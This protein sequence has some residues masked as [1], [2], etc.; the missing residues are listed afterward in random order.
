MPNLQLL[1]LFPLFSSFARYYVRLRAFCDSIEHKRL[2]MAP[3]DRIWGLGTSDSNRQQL[4]TLRER[5]PPAARQARPVDPKFEDFFGLTCSQEQRVCSL[6]LSI[7]VHD[8]L[9]SSIPSFFPPNHAWSHL[10]IDRNDSP[11]NLAPKLRGTSV[12]SLTGKQNNRLLRPSGHL[13]HIRCEG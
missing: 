11:G 2:R 9:Q 12:Q 7:A 3:A 5:W 10:S 4:R 8:A 13:V 6:A 1:T